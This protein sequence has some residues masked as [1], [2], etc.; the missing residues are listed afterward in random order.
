MA[1]GYLQQHE[2]KKV[3]P[4]KSTFNPMGYEAQRSIILMRSN[5]QPLGS[6]LCNSVVANS[7]G[8][9]NQQAIERA[10]EEEMK[11][12][13]FM[14]LPHSYVDAARSLLVDSDLFE[15]TEAGL[16]IPSSGR[17]SSGDDSILDG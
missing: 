6:Y 5:G 12:L 13:E 14:G 10:I 8:E 1:N 11:V 7:G 15:L 9:N 4:I 16:L 3:K 2:I 17:R